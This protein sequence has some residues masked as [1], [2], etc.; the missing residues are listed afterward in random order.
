MGR[1]MILLSGETETAS[2]MNNEEEYV[3]LFTNPCMPEYVKVGRTNDIKQRLSSLYKE[4][5]LPLPFECY[6]HI[7][8]KPNSKLNASIVEK[9]LHTILAKS[10]TKNKEFFKTTPDEV[11]EF[12]QC[13]V[14]M[15]KS[16]KLVMGDGSSNKKKGE[17]TTFKML[18]IKQGEELVHKTKKD[19]KCIVQNDNNSVLYNGEE[20]T[21]SA[22]ASN[23]ANGKPM[24][25]YEH[26]VCPASEFPN[27]T[28]WD[29]RKRLEKERL[30]MKKATK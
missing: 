8:V 29:R 16:L 1:V 25:G 27:E 4:T 6:A 21:L 15:N 14:E 22:I 12:F 3:Y 23:L 17:R 26:F 24:N 11:L 18:E 13:I 7:V 9:N 5:C 10:L 2:A 19:C 30:E 28:L 20:T